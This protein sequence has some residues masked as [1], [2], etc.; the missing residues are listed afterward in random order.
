MVAEM[1]G[2][3]LVDKKIIER[4]AALCKVDRNW[5]EAADE[6]SCGWWER[7]LHGFSHGGPEVYVG[8]HDDVMVDRDALQRFT[9]KVVEEAAKAGNCVIIGR[10]SQCVLR[11][12]P[13]VL[14]VM[15]YA[16]MAEKVERMRARH[17]QEQDLPALLKRMDAE[18]ARYAGEYFNCDGCDRRLYHLVLNSTLG[19][20]TCAG[21]VVDAVR[22]SAAKEQPVG[23]RVPA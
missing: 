4:A 14:H 18:R 6:Q 9:A 22:L 7:V 10:G 19:L 12:H 16:P 3:E 8:G 15:V 13:G 20:R 11:N 1:L 2:W 21:L 23:E 17:P 5:A